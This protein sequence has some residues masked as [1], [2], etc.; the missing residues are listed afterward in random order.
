MVA[1]LISRTTGLLAP[2]ASKAVSRVGTAIRATG[3]VQEQGIETLT[4][5]DEKLKDRIPVEFES[6]EDIRQDI[7]FLTDPNLIN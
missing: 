7:E 2:L 5:Q 3:E 1:P 6:A 4:G